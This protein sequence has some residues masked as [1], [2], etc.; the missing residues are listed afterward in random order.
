MTTVKA[1]G[2]LLVNPAS[3]DDSPSADE[4]EA[5]ARE[6]GV[7]VRVLAK[8]DDPGEL[9]RASGASVAGGD[10]SLSLVAQ[11]ALDTDAAF[12]CIPFGTR[13][14]FARDIGLD[15]DDP[16]AALAAFDDDAVERR[17]DAGRV[18]E[19]LFVNNVSLG[20]YAGLVHR[21]ERR[22]RRGEA[23]AR[24]RALG[25]VIRHRHH[26]HARVNGEPVSARVLLIGN[27]PYD[28]SLFTLGERERLD[29]GVLQL[30][31]AAGLLPT[32]WEDRVAREFRIKLPG[33]HVRAAV[34]G[35]PVLL[36][37]PLVFASLPGALRVRIPAD[38]GGDAMHDNPEPTEEEEE[39]AQT[40][41]QNEE[42]AQ[43]YP[44]TGQPDSPEDASE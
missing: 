27:N 34:D 42:E 31:S 2:Y 32:R 40:D 7:E 20:V 3:G 1:Q 13:N 25:A 19:R 26:L 39:L 23:L 10:G 28:V 16:L 29:R 44:S 36:E 17:I 35:E 33:A 37:P 24:L 21:R 18:G 15:R 11:A 43:R 9:A 41:R 5:A 6:R 30:W 22:R 4:L 8:E 12:V 14:H 38:G